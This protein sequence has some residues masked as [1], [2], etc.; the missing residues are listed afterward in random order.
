MT[1]ISYVGIIAIESIAKEKY[2]VKA[3]THRRL[4]IQESRNKVVD[5]RE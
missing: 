5:G 3:S 1:T 4:N 2:V